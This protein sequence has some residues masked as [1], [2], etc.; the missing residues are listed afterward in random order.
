M[1]TVY[2]RK[3]SYNLQKVMWLV[4]EL[5]LPHEHIERGGDFGGLDAPT[6]LAMNPHGRVPVIKDGD[7]VV[8]ESQAILR[9]LG[10]MYGRPQFWAEDAA[11]RSHPDRWLDWNA[12]SLQPDFLNGIFW[13]WYRTPAEKRNMSAVKAKFTACSRHMMLLDR[14]IGDKPFLL[15]AE[16]T[17]ADIAIGTAFHRYFNMEIPRPDVPRVEDWHHRLQERPGYRR[18]VMLPFAELYGR[19]AY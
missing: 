19:L 18:H 1:L 16:L 9:Y 11:T 10:A 14:V 12:T 3:S 8:W 6:F 4:A 15:G 7:T 5:G 13:G 2:G 17:L